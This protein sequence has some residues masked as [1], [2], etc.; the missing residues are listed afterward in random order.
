MKTRIP[1]SYLSGIQRIEGLDKGAMRE[2]LAAE[3]QGKSRM[4]AGQ[5]D[6]YPVQAIVNHNPYLSLKAQKRVADA[7]EEL[8]LD[9]KEEPESWSDSDLRAL[10]NLAAELR[11][12]DVKLKLVSLIESGGLAQIKTGL[13]APIFRAIATLSSNVDYKFWF[14]VPQTYPAFV[15]MAFQVLARI[16]PK[17]ALLLLRHLPVNADALE[18]VARKLP[19]FVSKFDAKEQA[20]VLDQITDALALLTPEAAQPLQLALKEQGF[21]L[22]KITFPI[23]AQHKAQ[24]V[25]EIIVFVQS[26]HI[27]NQLDQVYAEN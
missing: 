23:A 16:A 10:L 11:V 27:G 22:G 18:G 5:T 4:L 8:I 2:W 9:W 26:I 6:D 12:A 20:A 3:I 19:D 21:D 15:G 1:E 14:R 13:H 7:I 17:V 24:F 25:K